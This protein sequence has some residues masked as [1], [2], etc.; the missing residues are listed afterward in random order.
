MHVTI[1]IENLKLYK[2]GLKKYSDGILNTEVHAKGS[3]T[4]RP[5][6]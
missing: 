2:K 6:C 4:A 5:N 1:F 3:S